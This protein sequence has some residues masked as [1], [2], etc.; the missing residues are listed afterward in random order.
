MKRFS[1]VYPAAGSG[2]SAVEL[3]IAEVEKYSNYKKWIDVCKGWMVN[4]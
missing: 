1:T 4:K 2:N 3:S